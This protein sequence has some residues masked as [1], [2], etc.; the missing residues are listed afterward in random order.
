MWAAV[1]CNFL[2]AR[3]TPGNPVQALVAQHPHLGPEAIHALTVLLGGGFRRAW[4]FSRSSTGSTSSRSTSAVLAALTVLITSIGG[5][6]LTMRNNDI[7]VLADDHVRMA[8]AKGVKPWRTMWACAG[9][10]AIGH[11]LTGFAVSLGFVVS[12][13]I[14]V[15]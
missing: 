1:G 9:R 3:L 4:P 14:V 10:N 7:T 2:I 15:G 8:R 13:A 5:W 11:S 6:I 12:G